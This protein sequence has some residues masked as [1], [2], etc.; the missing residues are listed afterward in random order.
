MDLNKVV[1]TKGKEKV[2]GV[3]EKGQVTGMLLNDGQRGLLVM[4]KKPGETPGVK[5]SS[6]LPPTGW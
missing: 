1:R 5:E 2:Y 6:Q 3:I 4:S